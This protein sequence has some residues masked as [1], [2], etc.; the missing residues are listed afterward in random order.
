MGNTQRGNNN[1]YCQDSELSWIEWPKADQ[2][3]IEFTSQV[4]H[5]R[6]AHPV[7]TRRRWFQGQPIRGIGV[8]DIAWFRPDGEIMEQHNWDDDCAKSLGVFFNGLGLRCLGPK[9]EKMT[10]DNFYLLFNASEQPIEFKVPERKYGGAWKLIL[11]TS[12]AETGKPEKPPAPGQTITVAAQSIL[13][14]E[15]ENQQRRENP[16]A[17]LPEISEP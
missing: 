13:L 12:A 4:I 2:Q 9:G 15:S 11:D 7:F 5:F 10:D 14:F 6:K 16:L 8:E 17:S 1:S 3:L